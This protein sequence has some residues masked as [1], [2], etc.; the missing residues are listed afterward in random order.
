MWLISMILDLRTLFDNQQ[1]AVEFR[2]SLDLSEVR[3]RGENPFQTS[4]SL[5]GKVIGH[6]GVV[7]IH[8]TADFQLDTYCDR[9]L[10]R[11]G[12]PFVKQFS[13]TV[14]RELFDEN[15]E[16]YVVTADGMLDLAELA[17]ADILLSL[18]SSFLCKE[19]C[20]GL[21]PVCGQDRNEKECGCVI[22]QTDPRLAVLKSLLD[23]SIGN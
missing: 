5:E 11:L 18:P 8:Y 16:E 9:C 4:L 14:V 17:R 2:H 13:H 22:K 10:K 3:L 23:E 7:E 21:C 20:K 1:E 12:K 19:D 15:N 6:A